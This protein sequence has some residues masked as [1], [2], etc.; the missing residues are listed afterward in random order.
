VVESAIANNFIIEQLLRL[1]AVE[2][3]DSRPFRS[4]GCA[5]PP[6]AAMNAVTPA[7][8]AAE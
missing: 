5:F 7:Q 3:W 1:E 6:F 4:F 2:A 8:R